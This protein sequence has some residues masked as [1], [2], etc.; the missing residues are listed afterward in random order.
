M[1]RV[2]IRVEG[3]VRE[4]DHDRIWWNEAP[5]WIMMMERDVDG[6][7]REMLWLSFVVLLPGKDQLEDVG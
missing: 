4:Y 5:D 7:E 1:D 3:S 2:G 6:R